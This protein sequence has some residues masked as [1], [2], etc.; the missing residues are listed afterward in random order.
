[1]KSD[2]ESDPIVEPTKQS[3]KGSAVPIGTKQSAKAQSSVGATFDSRSATIGNDAQGSVTE[4]LSKLGAA[5]SI[6]DPLAPRR[7]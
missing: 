7:R 2:R 5:T 6:V 4:S 1:M 3:T